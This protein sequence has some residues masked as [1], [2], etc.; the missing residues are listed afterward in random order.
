MALPWVRLDSNIV[1]HDK[2]L[3]LLADP[4]PKRWQAIASHM[5]SLGWCG[6]AGTDGRIPTY[7]LT[8]VHGTKETAR[9]LEKHRLWDPI[10]T[11]WHIHNYE[12][13]QQLAEVTELKKRAAHDASIKANCVRWHGESCGCWKASA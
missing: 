6:A 4:S 8:T 11:G 2:M 7:A 3:A 9:L 10:V 12:E 1:I 13:Y 5:F